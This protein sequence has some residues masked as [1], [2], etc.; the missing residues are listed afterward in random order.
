MVENRRPQSG[1]AA[2]SSIARDSYPTGVR[3]GRLITTGAWPSS[4]SVSSTA[5]PRSDARR[6]HREFL[7]LIPVLSG[8]VMSHALLSYP[9]PLVDS[10]CTPPSR[11]GPILKPQLLSFL[12]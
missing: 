1:P 5:E 12:A 2:L 6:L 4:T 11:S 8:I 7:A 10:D 3:S 9:P